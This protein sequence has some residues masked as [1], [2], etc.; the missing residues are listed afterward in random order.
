MHSCCTAAEKAAGR[1]SGAP[2]ASRTG[3]LSLVVAAKELSS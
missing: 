2:M 1:S 3:V